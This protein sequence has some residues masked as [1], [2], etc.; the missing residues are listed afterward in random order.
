MRTEDGGRRRRE[1][2][3]RDVPI[4]CT[5][6]AIN[7][8]RFA[9][10]RPFCACA[11]S[12]HASLFSSLSGGRS[13]RTAGEGRRRRK[14][15]MQAYLTLCALQH[16]RRCFQH[17]DAQQQCTAEAQANHLDPRP[18]IGLRIPRLCVLLARGGERDRERMGERNKEREERAALPSPLSDDGRLAQTSSRSRQG[19]GGEVS[20]PRFSTAR[21]RARPPR[22]LS[23]SLAAQHSPLPQSLPRQTFFFF[24]DNWLLPFIPQAP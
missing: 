5:W 4:R 13:S 23:S 19:G 24:W 10:A 14:L 11:S 21:S 6:T 3:E 22:P 15:P 16:L 8:P 9:R 2:Q 12:D 7:R 20:G 1:Q 18:S 17:T